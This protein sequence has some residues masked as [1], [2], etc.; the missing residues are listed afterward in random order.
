MIYLLIS[1]KIFKKTRHNGA[2]NVSSFN[3]NSFKVEDVIN[4]SK[5]IIS[6]P[7]IKINKNTKHYE[8][9]ELNL[10]IR[11]IKKIFKIRNKNLSLETVLR[12]TYSWYLD[13]N[14]VK[15]FMIYQRK[16]L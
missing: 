5:R 10:D 3:L 11:K 2:Y 16:I 1:E 14:K 13:T 12:L 15:I 7:K 6:L 4:I 9:Q 8:S